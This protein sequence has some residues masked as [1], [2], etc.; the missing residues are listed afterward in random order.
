MQEFSRYSGGNNPRRNRNMVVYLVPDVG[1]YNTLLKAA[2]Q[3]LAALQLRDPETARSYGLERDDLDELTRV[4]HDLNQMLSTDAVMLY[5][6]LYYPVDARPDGSLV[7]EAATVNQTAIRREGFCRAVLETLKERGKLVESIAGTYL[8]RIAA[9]RYEALRRP[10]KLGDLVAAFTEDPRS[11][12]LLH[13][14]ERVARAAS[15]LLEKGL[16]AA[17]QPDGKTVC[18]RKLRLDEKLRLVPCTAPEA[19]EACIV[20]ESPEGLLECRPKPPSGCTNP[21][22][23]SEK[24]QWICRAEPVAE[25]HTA[26]PAAAAVATGPPAPAPAGLELEDVSPP[27]A[28]EKLRS[29]AAADKPIELL[30]VRTEILEPD[31]RLVAAV[32][33]LIQSLA[34]LR[35]Q[36]PGYQLH[37]RLLATVGSPGERVT[38]DAETASPNR[39]AQ[40]L[41]IA[42]GLGAGKLSRIV[43]EAQLTRSSEQKPITVKQLADA[44]SWRSLSNPSLR[45]KIYIE[46]GS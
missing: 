3:L 12:I 1:V 34:T 29:T 43:L 25:K 30:L 13:P 36:A 37:A 14:A 40:V 46:T 44:L 2:A 23:D 39:L 33:A 11:V 31:D 27:E 20:E 41:S 8:L 21:V 32:R 38:I 19:R 22:W 24:R 9:Q 35:Q 5:G 17:L 18:M 15:S 6:K 28:A 4:I 7:F 16:L 10:L 26:A 42:R 45:L